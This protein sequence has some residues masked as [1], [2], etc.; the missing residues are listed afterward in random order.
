GT[1]P[2]SDPLSIDIRQALQILSARHHIFVLGRTSPSAVSGLAK[3]ASI[4][5]SEPVVY[6]EHHVAQAG[7]ILILGV[8]VVVVVHVMDRR[9]HLRRWPAVNKDERWG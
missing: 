4:H 2:D 5:D 8:S 9:Q 7:Q 3:R 1:A 6:R